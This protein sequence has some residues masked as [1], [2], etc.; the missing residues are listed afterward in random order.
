MPTAYTPG[1]QVTEYT[2]IRTVRRLPLKGE[3]LVTVGQRV[4]ADDVVARALL[5]GAIQAVRAADQLGVTPA[6]LLRLLK[7]HE[8]DLIDA[9]EVL[10][11]TKGFLGLF[12]AKLHA[13]AAGVIEYISQLTGTLGVREHPVPL[14]MTAYIAGTVEDNG[15]VYFVP[16]FSGLFAPYWDMYARGA[17]LGLTRSRMAPVWDG[18]QF[19]A[20]NML[21]MSLSYDHRAVDGALAAG[22]AATLRHLLGDVRRIML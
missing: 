2:T 11:E 19:V 3:V 9:G 14:E 4:A 6:E 13:P 10:A 15:G 18:E 7:K 21:P 1:L 17:I 8:G 22:F 20:R 12:G 16:A 5:P